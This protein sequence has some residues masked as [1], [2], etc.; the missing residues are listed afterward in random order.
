[1]SLDI[2]AGLREKFP[3]L[4]AVLLRVEGVEVRRELP[5]LEAFKGEVY[6]RTRDAWTLDQLREEP[7]F[8]AY[9]D[10]FWRVGVDPTKTRPAAEALIRRVLRGRPIPKINTFVD[11]YNLASIVSTIP[12][13]AFDLDGLSGGLLMREAVEGE[14]FVGISMEK[15]VIL[16]GGETVVED[17]E[18]LVAIYPYRDADESKITMETEDVLLMVCGVPNIG[19]DT[20]KDASR[21]ALDYVTRF[22]GG[23]RA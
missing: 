5:A 14:T 21:I 2:E 18:K 1:M 15:P 9:R 20:L 22:C 23:S 6:E 11:S 16:R 19:G 10:F 4:R 8:R 12:L 13:A 17:G 7:V 3:G